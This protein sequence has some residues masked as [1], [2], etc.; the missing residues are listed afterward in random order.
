MKAVLRVMFVFRVS[1]QLRIEFIIS[2][3]IRFRFSFE[4][5]VGF[6]LRVG[7]RI[8]VRSNSKDRVRFR[9]TVMNQG[10]D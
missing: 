9:V 3:G 6:S 10:L 7:F 4:V 1:V 2:L 5:R 8:C